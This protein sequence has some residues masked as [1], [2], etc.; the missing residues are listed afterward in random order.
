MKIALLYKK[1]FKQYFQ[2]KD[3]FYNLKLKNFG[4]FAN[5]TDNGLILMDNRIVIPK[6]FRKQILISLHSAHQ[7][8]TGM[9]ARTNETVYWPGMDASIRNYHANCMTCVK[10]S[11]SNTRE[12]IIFTPSPEWPFQHIV[13]DLCYVG[14]HTYLVCADR[15]TGWLIIY[16]LRPNQAK[17]EKPITI[18]RSL[19]E[20]YGAPD[21]IGSKGGPPFWAHQ[22][23]KFLTSWDIKHRLSSEAYPQSNGRA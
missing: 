16:H 17:A 2:R 21:E 1:L 5:C 7:G 9:K 19:F 10:H 15:L 6:K 11:P 22:F 18:C 20:K 13:L 8:I 14:H 3:H 12:P 4:R 23:E